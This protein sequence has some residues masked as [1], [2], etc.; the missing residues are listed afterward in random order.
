MPLFIY[1][2][3]YNTGPHLSYHFTTVI[4][5]NLYLPLWKPPISLAVCSKRDSDMTGNHFKIIKPQQ[6]I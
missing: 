5:N 1:E 6:F 4:E 2:S 3:V